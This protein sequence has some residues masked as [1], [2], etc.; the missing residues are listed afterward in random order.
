MIIV[1]AGC[2]PIILSSEQAEERKIIIW[3]DAVPKVKVT[4]TKL[5]E[6][7]SEEDLRKILRIRNIGMMTSR[8][9]ELLC[10]D[11]SSRDELLAKLDE[12]PLG[13]VGE[14]HRAGRRYEER[15]ASLRTRSVSNGKVGEHVPQ[16]RRTQNRF[17]PLSVAEVEGIGLNIGVLNA[18]GL[19]DLFVP[20]WQQAEVA[21]LTLLA[22]TE[23]YRCAGEKPYYLPGY[24]CLESQMRPGTRRMVRVDEDSHGV[25]FFVRNDWARAV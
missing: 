8:R 12:N 21:P 17:A 25:G 6:V 14:S 24:R 9:I 18:N 2:D 23:T 7:L 11:I 22:V 4:R 5:S 10:D 16:P 1:R 20:V 13:F 19:S 15:K 3:T